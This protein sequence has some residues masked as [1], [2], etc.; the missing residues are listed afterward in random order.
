MLQLDMIRVVHATL[1]FSDIPIHN[2]NHAK[3]FRS[4]KELHTYSLPFKDS[5]I[6][7]V[8]SQAQCCTGQPIR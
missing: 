8:T 1:V 6:E 5:C 3:Y 4:K 2:K 7:V